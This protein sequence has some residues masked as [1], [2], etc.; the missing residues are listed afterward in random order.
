[1]SKWL[2]ANNSG[3]NFLF[4]L[5][6]FHIAVLPISGNMAAN[7]ICIKY[8]NKVFEWKE[9]TYGSENWCMGRADEE[10]KNYACV[11]LISICII[12]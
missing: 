9:M 11:W 3:N 7:Y 5:I 12:N 8:K 4:I 10:L 1:M 2:T 6:V